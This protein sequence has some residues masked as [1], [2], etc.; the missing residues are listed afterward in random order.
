MAIS[1]ERATRRRRGWC[2]VRRQQLRKEWIGRAV[3]GIERIFAVSPEERSGQIAA[4]RRREFRVVGG[5]D[6]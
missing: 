5:R 3:E 1:S 2:C 6:G 4:K